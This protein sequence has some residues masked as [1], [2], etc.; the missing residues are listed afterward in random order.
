MLLTQLIDQQQSTYAQIQVQ[1]EALQEQ[2]RQIQAYLQRLGSVE[3]QMVSAAQVIQ[4]AIASIN[5]VCPDELASYK[6]LISGLFNKPLAALPGNDDDP[7]P[8]DPTPDPT[9][10]SL[11]I[12]EETIEAIAVESEVVPQPTFVLN[13]V[14]EA[15]ANNLNLAQLQDI[16]SIHQLNTSG[17]QKTLKKRFTNYCESVGEEEL[18]HIWEY[19]QHP[20][21]HYN[22]A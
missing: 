12:E 13:N 1:I 21:S 22:A 2:Q 5:E 18:E 20:T 7:E 17:N 6:E 19:L 8:T 14:K 16:L 4:E 15:I 3:S 10:E 9:I 11:P